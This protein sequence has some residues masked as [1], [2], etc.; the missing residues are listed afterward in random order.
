MDP[1]FAG[2]IPLTIPADKR[3]LL[4]EGKAQFRV[5]TQYIDN[6]KFRSEGDTRPPQTLIVTGHYEEPDESNP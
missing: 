4:S 3:T 1:S 2:S 6:L 5:T